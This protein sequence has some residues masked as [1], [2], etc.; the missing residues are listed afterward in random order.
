MQKNKQRNCSAM[1]RNHGYPSFKV[2]RVGLGGGGVLS[3]VGLTKARPRS[4]HEQS[5]STRNI[6]GSIHRAAWHTAVIMTTAGGLQQDIM[7]SLS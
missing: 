7:D 3:F 5:M 6:S 2:I 1:V 4:K